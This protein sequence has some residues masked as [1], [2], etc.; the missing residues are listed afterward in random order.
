MASPRCGVPDILRE[1]ED[2]HREKRYV[3]GSIDWKKGDL[4][5][6]YVL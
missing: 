3:I 5:Y 4:T 1:K 6:L 2:A